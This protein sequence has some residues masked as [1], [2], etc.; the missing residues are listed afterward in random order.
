MKAL[1]IRQPWAWLVVEGHKDIENR[2]WYIRQRGRVF[3]H[4]SKGCTRDEYA[5][6]C[7]FAEPLLPPGVIIPNLIDL[8]RGGLVGSVEIVKCSFQSHSPWFVG[9]YGAVLK[10]PKVMEFRPMAGQL[11]F[12][13]VPPQ[14]EEVQS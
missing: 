7:A 4:A 6:A 12:F 10:N 2:S 8:P 1:S 5:C 3:V 9:I 11:G 13:D 14:G